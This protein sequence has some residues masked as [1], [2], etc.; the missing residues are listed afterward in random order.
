MLGTVTA[1]AVSPLVVDDADT[2]EPGHFQV[3]PDFQFVRKDSVCLYSI[4]INPVVGLNARTELGVIFGYQWRDGSGSTPTT[5]D[6][7]GISDFTIV[8][9]MWLW[10]GL[11]DRLKFSTRLDIKLPT[12]SEHRELGTGNPDI[13]LVAIATYK[14]GKTNFD[15]NLGY[16]AINVSRSELGDDHWF[17]GLAVRRELTNGWTILAETY[18]L[19]PHTRADGSANFYFSGGPQWN[20]SEHII[21]SALVGTAV[22]HDSPDLTGTLE[23][24]F[25]F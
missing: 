10:Q 19:L 23:L 7:K 16:S 11:D 12:A 17:A 21:F 8:P 24:A 4:P 9:K 20:I 15:W 5:G 13:G 14:D 3:N 18:A 6:A 2:T 22:G 1:Y 25:A